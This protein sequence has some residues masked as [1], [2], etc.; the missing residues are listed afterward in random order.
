[1]SI[2]SRPPE[3]F[4]LTKSFICSVLGCDKPLHDETYTK[5]NFAEN[6]SEGCVAI[7]NKK[8]VNPNK[9]SPPST[10]EGLA[11]TAIQKGA[12]LLISPIQIKDYP[13]IISDHVLHAYIDIVGAI[14]THYKARAIAITGSIGKSTTTEM[15]YAVISSKYKTP[16]V[17]SD[18][19]NNNAVRTVGLKVQHLTYDDEFYVQEVMEGP[20][21]GCAGQ[22][23][24][25]VQPSAA[26]ITFIGT[27]HIKDFLTQDRILESCLSIQDGMPDD[28]LLIM[29]GDDPFQWSAETRCRKVY[30]ALD[31]DQA[32]YRAV[33]IRGEN[34]F[35]KFDILHHGTVTPVEIQCYGK[36]NV[37]DALAAFAAG[38]WAGMKDREIAAGLRNYHPQGIRQNFVNYAG[39]RF[40]LDCYNAAMESIASA[41]DAM[42]MIDP[43][44]SSRRYA[45]LGDIAESETKKEEIH[46]EVGRIAVNSGIDHLICYGADARMIAAY[47]LENSSMPVYHTQ[48]PERL[49]KYLKEELRPGDIVLVKGSR[50]MQLE[51]VIDLAYGTW[52]HEEFE[53][54]DSLTANLEE[55]GIRYTVFTDHAA[56]IKPVSEHDSLVLPSLVGGKP[57]TGISS[58]AFQSSPLRSVVFPDSL[59]N[60]RRAAF[61]KAGNLE[62]VHIPGSVEIIDRGAFSTCGSLREVTIENGCGHL[63]YRA[64]ASCRALKSIIIPPSVHYIGEDAFHNCRRLTIY[65]EKGSLAERY[66]KENG[67]AF[68]ALS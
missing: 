54:Y 1:M 11:D 40:Y 59:R 10:W 45:I 16:V 5:I 50:S 33:N 64:F 38:K 57:L 30:Y 21:V 37:L 20:P 53:R 55:D 52:L 13:C 28:G 27:S 41:F 67:I 46:H 61:Y 32:D 18:G 2:F 62:T 60:I 65:G 43:N 26:I 34:D 23:A 68:A 19:S 66:A 9:L 31:N 47:A 56:L 7:V 14:R 22:I 51:H 49:A 44:S 29:N 4:V 58:Y 24:R 8:T 6:A 63:G 3:S 35:L 25:M 36:H 39:I 42:S 17:K 15:T 12:K 48:D